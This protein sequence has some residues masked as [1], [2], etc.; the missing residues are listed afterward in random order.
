MK[1]PTPTPTI[2]TL[3]LTLSVHSQLKT[4]VRELA[5][6]REQEVTLSDAV[7]HLL[8]LTKSANL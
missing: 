4:L 1:Q 8:D 7:Q 5:L 2:T 3:R 6:Q